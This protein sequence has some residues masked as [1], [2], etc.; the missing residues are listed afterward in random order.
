MAGLMKGAYSS[1][2]KITSQKMS[3]INVAKHLWGKVMGK[4]TSTNIETVIYQGIRKGT[5]D[6]I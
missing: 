1:I 6:V 3:H 5:W 4:V 2:A